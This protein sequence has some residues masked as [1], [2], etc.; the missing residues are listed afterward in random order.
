[1]QLLP[2]TLT[3][4][5]VAGLTAGCT[6]GSSMSL[7]QAPLTFFAQDD[8]GLEVVADEEPPAAGTV[9]P[10]MLEVRPDGYSTVGGNALLPVNTLP[11]ALLGNGPPQ[12]NGGLLADTARLSVQIGSGQIS[13]ALDTPLLRLNTGLNPGTLGTT[14]AAGS[15]LLPAAEANLALSLPAAVPTLTAPV[16]QLAPVVSS[17]TSAVA[18]VVSSTTTSLAQTVAPLPALAP[19]APV[20]ANVGST[21]GQTLTTVGALLGSTTRITPPTLPT[22]RNDSGILAAIAS[23]LSKRCRPPRCK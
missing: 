19:V 22:N 4:L 2:S 20:V 3:L 17:T 6:T 5:A 9:I 21:A 18:T 7:S 8:G 15:P 14:V 1:M 16:G 11:P 10:A 12:A 23:E 13:A